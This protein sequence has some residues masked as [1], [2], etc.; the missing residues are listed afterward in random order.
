M[1]LHQGGVFLQDL[2]AGPH[3][4]LIEQGMVT[5]ASGQP[6]HST[7]QAEGLK[8]GFFLAGRNNE[9]DSMGTDVDGGEDR[10]IVTH[11]HPGIPFRVLFKTG[12][13]TELPCALRRAEHIFFA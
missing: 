8:G 6:G 10:L 4:L 2:E 11:G 9:P 13:C 7:L 3:G 5:E 12:E 1:L